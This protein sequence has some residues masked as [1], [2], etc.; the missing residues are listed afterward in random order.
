[1]SKTKDRNLESGSLKAKKKIG[2]PTSYGVAIRGYPGTANNHFS[3]IKRTKGGEKNKSINVNVY[4][5]KKGQY[6]L[7]FF[8]KKR[9]VLLLN[10]VIR[11]LYV[12]M[13]QW[14]SDLILLYGQ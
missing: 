7:F 11:Q 14:I 13:R 10:F 1:M 6:S 5:G 8:E 9:I 4:G 3:R 2:A 12:H